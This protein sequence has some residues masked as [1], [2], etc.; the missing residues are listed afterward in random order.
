M[1]NLDLQIET[2]FTRGFLLPPTKPVNEKGGIVHGYEIILFSEDFDGG[3]VVDGTFYQTVSG[4]FICCKPG[5]HRKFKLPVRSYM[6]T[7][8]TQDIQ[9]KAALDNLPAYAHAPNMPELMELYWK[10]YYIPTHTDLPDRLALYSHFAT[11]LQ[12]LLRNEYPLGTITPANPRR[13]REALLAA[14][15]YLKD[16][17]E[18]DVDLKKLAEASHLHPTYF[19]KLFTE[20]F[21]RS[22]AQR[23][24]LH[25][26]RASWEYLRRDDCTIAE[27]ARKCGFSSQSYFCRKYKEISKQT[28]SAYRQA[29]R[30]RRKKGSAKS[31]N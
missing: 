28:P 9:L 23:L 10:M 12:L 15:Q 4:Y 6:I 21:G 25:R 8:A 11:F 20:A 5:Q 19:H 18:E 17:L 7:F 2:Q 13:H 16:H 1:E 30:R 29:M 3:V 26:I 27:I 22:P 14:D 31:N 24:M